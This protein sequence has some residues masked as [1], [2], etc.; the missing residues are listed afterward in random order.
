MSQY[1]AFRENYEQSDSEPEI[2]GKGFSSLKK[3]WYFAIE[4]EYLNYEIGVKRWTNYATDNPHPDTYTILDSSRDI[5]S[6]HTHIVFNLPK[7]TKKYKLYMVITTPNQS[8]YVIRGDRQK[9]IARFDKIMEKYRKER[10][11]TYFL[12][13]GGAI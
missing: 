13:N 5:R 9:I 3:V 2:I 10:L 6:D 7:K 8:I 11:S 1:T 4:S 12:S